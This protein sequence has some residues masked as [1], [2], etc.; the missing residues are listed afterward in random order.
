MRHVKGNANLGRYFFWL[1]VCWA[2]VQN[3]SEL[4]SNSCLVKIIMYLFYCINL[5]FQLFVRVNWVIATYAPWYFRNLLFF[6]L[7]VS[8]TILIVQF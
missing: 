7:L 4:I 2:G 3:C 6:T 8:V 1:S 5:Y